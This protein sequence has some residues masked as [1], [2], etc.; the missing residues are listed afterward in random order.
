MIAK[1][2]WF[3]QKLPQTSALN[4]AGL[5]LT[6]IKDNSLALSIWA[7]NHYRP[8]HFPCFICQKQK[9]QQEGWNTEHIYTSHNDKESFHYIF[10]LFIVYHFIHRNVLGEALKTVTENFYDIGIGNLMCITLLLEVFECKKEKECI[11]IK[12]N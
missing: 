8:L 3:T 12:R 4:P 1:C 7:S 2:Y 10:R 9:L 5:K 6:F 11:N